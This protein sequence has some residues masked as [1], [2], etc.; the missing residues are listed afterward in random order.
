MTNEEIKAGCI[1]LEKF[2]GMPEHGLRTHWSYPQGEI[3][4]HLQLGLLKDV[5]EALRKRIPASFWTLDSPSVG[6]SVS[7]PWSASFWIDGCPDIYTEGATVE[8]AFFAACLEA[9]VYIEKEK[10]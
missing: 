8:E 10:L 1:Q 4:I 3:Q 2:A 7:D 6:E 9:L 5:A